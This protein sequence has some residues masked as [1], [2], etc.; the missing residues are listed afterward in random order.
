MTKTKNGSAHPGV[1]LKFCR[2]VGV[3]QASKT[4]LV[5]ALWYNIR[6]EREYLEV[7]LTG[8]KA[9]PVFGKAKP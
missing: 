8:L 3:N 1:P 2:A 4:R 6:V 9:R 7:S 5:Q